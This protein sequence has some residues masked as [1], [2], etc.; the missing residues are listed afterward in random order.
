[1]Q[2]WRELRE[3]YAEHVAAEEAR[4][5]RAILH[6]QALDQREIDRKYGFWQGVKAILDTPGQAEEALKRLD[7]GEDE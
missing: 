1:M 3:Q 5:G 4:I 2:V 6:G 7:E